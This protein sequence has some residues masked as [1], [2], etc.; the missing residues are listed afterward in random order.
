MTI[1]QER[2]LEKYGS[3][4]AIAVAL[5]KGEVDSCDVQWAMTLINQPLILAARAH[6]ELGFDK[7]KG[8]S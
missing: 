8:K 4:F 5:I 2:V 7:K 1:G 3:E 6:I